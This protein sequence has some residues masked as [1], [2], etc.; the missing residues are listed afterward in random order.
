MDRRPTRFPSGR[1]GTRQTV[2]R[3]PDPPRETRVV[4][5]VVARALTFGMA[6]I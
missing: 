6:A 4:V 1:F 3:M 5:V 2:T